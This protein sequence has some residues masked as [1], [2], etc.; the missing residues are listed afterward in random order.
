[1][2]VLRL[3]W[4]APIEARR[5]EPF[6]LYIVRNGTV[7]RWAGCTLTRCY[8]FGEKCEKLVADFVYVVC[9]FTL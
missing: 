5:T 1:M 3:E 8:T 9:N 2:F 4:K 6:A 7:P